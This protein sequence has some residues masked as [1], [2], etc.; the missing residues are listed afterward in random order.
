MSDFSVIIKG[1]RIALVV[2]VAW[3]VYLVLTL[4]R[5]PEAR[6]LDVGL[7]AGHTSWRPEVGSGQNVARVSFA[8]PPVD[9]GA[10]VGSATIRV[11]CYT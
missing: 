10:N 1:V 5:E 7:I 6:M 11:P 9:G 4:V 8:L 2:V 3:V